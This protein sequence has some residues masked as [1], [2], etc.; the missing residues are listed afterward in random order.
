MAAAP[1]LKLADKQEIYKKLLTGLKKRYPAVPK[2]PDLPVLET[3]LFAVCLENATIKDADAAFKRLLAAFH[4]LNEIRVSSIDELEVVFQG[5]SDPDW[6]AS[7][8]RGILGYVFEANYSFEYEGLKRKTL[9]LATK[10]LFKI[11]ELTPFVRD[12]T[13]HATLGAHLIPLDAAQLA[14]IEFLDLQAETGGPEHTAETLRPLVRKAEGNEFCGL[15][16]EFSLDPK[17]RP[18]FG[19]V[20]QISVNEGATLPSPTA[21][22]DKL[23]KGETIKYEGGHARKPAAAPEKKSPEKKPPEK[24]S[25]DKKGAI[26]A[27]P[28]PKPEPIADKKAK[29]VPAKSAPTKT[30]PAKTTPAKFHAPTPSAKPAKPAPAKSKP[31]PSVAKQDASK[32][33]SG[34]KSVAPAKTQPKTAPKPAA[35][36]AAKPGKKPTKSGK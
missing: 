22:L 10:Q 33:V 21:R 23:F 36:P 35:K 16:K 19:I 29:P 28:A 30:P 3:M 20:K 26:P 24:K 31:V 14:V 6:R 17:F 12:Y 32:K 8:I 2:P 18:Q 1:R 4:D 7:R 15:L 34:K 9:E 13:L 27:T 5:M 11:K 25:A